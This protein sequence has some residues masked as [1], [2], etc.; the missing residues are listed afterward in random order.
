M[1]TIVSKTVV[2]NGPSSTWGNLITNGIHFDDGTPVTV[3]KALYI[4]FLAPAGATVE[5]DNVQL[6]PWQTSTSNIAS[7]PAT[8][9]NGIEVTAEVL[10][11]APH[12]FNS[13]D[14][15]TWGIGGDLTGD[16]SRYTSSF[17]LYA[18]KLPGGS[19]DVNVAAAPDSALSGV[20][21]IITLTNSGLTRI[22]EATPGKTT[23]FDVPSGEWTVKAGEL[24]NADET[25]AATPS[26]T[27]AVIK[28]A[29]G[30]AA[31][32]HVSYDGAQK[33]ATLNVIVGQL[34]SALSGE[35]L[36]GTAVVS[37]GK[38]RYFESPGNHTTSLRRMPVS[39]K[40]TV[41]VEA[42]V[43]NVRYKG[44]KEVALPNSVVE[45]P[46]DEFSSTSIDSSGFADLT[47]A[48]L[49][50]DPTGATVTV[51]L[52]DAGQGKSVYRQDVT[53]SSGGTAKFGIPMATG[54]YKVHVSG[55]IQSG[56]VYGAQTAD[57]ISVNAAATLSV[58]FIRGPN[59][60]VPG[61][62]DYLSF[63]ALSDLVDLEGKDLAAAKVTSIFK[64]AGNDGA[65]DASVFLGTDP[66]TAK[67][68]NLAATVSAAL[69]GQKVLP[70]MISYTVNL[71][72]GDGDTHLRNE[73]GLMHSFAN[74]ILSL[75]TAKQ[76]SKNDVPAVYIINPDFL[77]DGQQQHRL[78]TFTMKVIDPLAKAMAHHKIEGSIP[79]AATDTLAGY[80]QAV[81]WLIRTIAPNVTFGWQANLWGV[82]AATWIYK[83]GDP[84]NVATQAK[85]TANYIKA[86]G[87]Y[88]GDYAPHFLAVDRY[89]A[90]DFTPR[91][92][93]NAF[94]YGP[95]EWAKFYDFCETLAFELTVPIMPWQIP[96]S[97]IPSVKDTATPS[98]LED[99]HWG[100]GGT[101]LFGDP[102]IGSETR[103]IHPAVLAIKPNALVGSPNVESLFRGEEP[104]DVSNSAYEDFPLRGI[105]TV[106][107]GGGATTGVVSSIGKTGPWTQ[108]KVSK[109]MAAPTTLTTSKPAKK[110]AGHA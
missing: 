80:V 108:E 76:T 36:F 107:L 51:R 29:E 2:G 12:T 43:N 85:S 92:Y 75:L 31:Q 47:I 27:P 17:A 78:P 28:V 88:S 106:L 54:T 65:G 56:V 94:C 33:Y 1:P 62:P 16:A 59:L 98:S 45:A 9:K 82:G 24:V 52:V 30:A 95:S 50:V 37:G 13:A 68:V 7:K 100:T 20:K 11:D 69:G 25:V 74:L 97:R 70:V 66:A 72:G 46:I 41:T 96:A 86:L 5:L 79:L 93:S 26:V 71:S 105:F 44:S 32:L 21:Q 8:D 87:V 15:L 73:E 38:E 64:Y 6:N 58:T 48:G 90:D 103:N 40:V 49:G 110:A 63:G 23:S 53:F 104:F 109:Y 61:F 3:Q 18:D 77:G 57:Q 83:K 101:Y 99:D 39:E 42:I 60:L 4:K 91:A 67:T 14:T 10:L 89:E 35:K 84:Q 34:P 55:H 19:V 22:L 81:N 102:A